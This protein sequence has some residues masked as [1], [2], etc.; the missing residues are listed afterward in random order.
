MFF[1]NV[2]I[3]G[4]S[5]ID[6]PHQIASSDLEARLQD[7]LQRFGM[8]P[9]L[10]ESLTGI[11]Y[12]RF[13]DA[14]AEPNQYAAEVARQALDKAG[15]SK[16]KVGVLISSSVYKDFIEPS[17]AAIVHG[18]LEL[19]PTCLNF[20]VSNACLGFLNSM[21]IAGNM[22]E[23]GQIDYA[24][25]TSCESAREINELTLERL[26]QPDCSEAE[27][28]AR[29]ATLTLGSAAVAMVLAHK[30][31]APEGHPFLG[32]VSM[33][34]TQHSRLCL[35]HNHDMQTDARG[36][37][38]AGVELAMKTYAY[39]SEEMA[40]DKK[41]FQQYIMHQVGAA[42][43][44]ALIEAGRIP[45]D[46]VPRIYQDYGNTGSTTVPLALMKAAEQNLLVRG[47]RVALMGI[48]SGINCSMMEMIW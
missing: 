37:L 28:R 13:W 34:A 35:G 36:L 8:R 17:I 32:G 20:D 39:A 48:G 3:M 42:H 43:L 6:A 10:I 16:D 22:I 30:D 1:E 47:E 15:L 46:R 33:A 25:L 38:A 44:N 23:R 24:L 9:N 26:S 12:R 7:N 2:N 45:P 14:E 40:W 18:R 29:F 19:P 11:Q 4:M 21:E 5:Y 41:D 27:F 31:L